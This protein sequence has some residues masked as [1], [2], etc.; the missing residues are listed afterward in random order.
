MSQDFLVKSTIT[1]M[2]YEDKMTMLL[3]V[4]GLA[5]QCESV[6]SMTLNNNASLAPSWRARGV[7]ADAKFFAPDAVR[8][9]AK[10]AAYGAMVLPLPKAVGRR[11]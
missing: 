9:P 6:D 8:L 5:S 11:S 2:S 4:I 1:S 10:Y 3:T 7:C